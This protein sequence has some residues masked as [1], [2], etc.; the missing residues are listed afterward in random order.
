MARTPSETAPSSE[1]PAA[2]AGGLDR[3][4]VLQGLAVGAAGLA[5]SPL[6]AACGGSSSAKK[7]AGAPAAASTP[8]GT[9]S[10]GSNGSDDVPKAAFAAVAAAFTA[11]TGV[12]VATNTVAHNDFQ[13]QINNYLQG[14]PDDVFTWFAGNRMRFSPSRGWSGTSPT[15]GV[16]CR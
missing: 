5:G 1:L 11:K 8:S 4:R 2:L 15:S 6:L 7:S 9:V 14:K 10:F 16:T 12:Q 3:R 13:E